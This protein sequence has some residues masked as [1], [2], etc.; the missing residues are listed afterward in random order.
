MSAYYAAPG[1]VPSAPARQETLAPILVAFAGPSPQSRLTVLVRILM[2]I[3]QLI[4]LGL[5]GIAVYVITI[6]GWF[7]ALFTGRLPVFAADFLT[8]YLRWTARVYAY[9]LLL[10]DVYPPFSLE[11]ADYPVRV[12]AMPGRLNRLAVLFRFF[13][14]IPAWIVVTVVGYGAFTIVQ[15]VTWL[16]VLISGRMP[17][18]LYAALA[19]ALRYQIRAIGFAVML[20]SAYPAG[21][22]GDREQPG[23]G[24]Q[25]GY[26]TQPGYGDALG[27]GAQPGYGTQA[28]YGAAQGF[29]GRPDAETGGE[30]SW[31]LIL[32]GG[33]RKLMVAF[34]V[35][36]VLLV[37]V[38]GAFE[39]AFGA[40]ATSAAI[41]ASASGQ[42]QADSVPVSSAISDYSANAT[43]C[44][45]QVS[46]ITGLDRRV[47]TALDT[48]AGQLRA[49]PMPTGQATSADA[50]LAASVS[51]TA[52]I[53]AR[54]G[55]ATSA[56]QYVSLADSSN[57]QQSVNQVN[58]D[59][60]NLGDALNSY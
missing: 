15:F 2:V 50:A 17:D 19:A 18:A 20:T 26:G 7:G 60:T 8:G 9:T 42:V 43:A 55:A 39:A 30:P 36:G 13:L 22:F 35:I 10:T 37:V 58:Q 44:H 54:L 40:K 51:R 57:L 24:A 52:S 41:A 21:L 12:A 46:C 29:V 25:P 56:S 53:F 32:S 16:I 4:V 14:L 31:R 11:D 23:Y 3:P 48:F 34:I 49:I 5:L 6:I 27:Y 38:D 1:A 59:Y 33:A 45:G 28:G 47:A